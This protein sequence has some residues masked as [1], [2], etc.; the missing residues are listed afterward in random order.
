MPPFM[1]PDVPRLYLDLDHDP[2]CPHHHD[3]EPIGE[4]K[5]PQLGQYFFFLFN[6]FSSS[7]VELK[8]SQLG[9]S[10]QHKNI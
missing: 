9:L 3:R 10:A 8:S 2:T 7:I 1:L 4:Q 6:F 5:S